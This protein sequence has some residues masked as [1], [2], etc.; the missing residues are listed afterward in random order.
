M[1][2]AAADLSSFKLDENVPPEGAAIFLSAGHDCHT[3]YDERLAGA[4][5]SVIATTCNVEQRILITMDLDFSDVRRY[6]PKSHPGIIVLR[7]PKG[8]KHT[9]LRLLIRI[10]HLLQT[11]PVSGHLWIVDESR[12]RIR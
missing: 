10:S 2:S 4:N 5:D 7:A 3:V 11:Q 9:I 6:P 12:V 1:Q 8:T